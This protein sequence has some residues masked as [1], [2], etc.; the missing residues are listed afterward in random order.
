MLRDQTQHIQDF[1]NVHFF[2]WKWRNWASGRMNVNHMLEAYKEHHL[3]QSNFPY[4]EKKNSRHKWVR[5]SQYKMMEMLDHNNKKKR[6][7]IQ[8]QFE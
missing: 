3:R 4:Y 8:I 2:D 6:V 5:E 7:H 1:E